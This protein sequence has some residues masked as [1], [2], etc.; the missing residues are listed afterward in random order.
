MAGP[1]DAFAPALFASTQEILHLQRQTA[2]Q[3]KRSEDLARAREAEQKANAV[4]FEPVV[5]YFAFNPAHMNKVL[6]TLREACLNSQAGLKPGDGAAL[7]SAVHERFE[8][9]VNALRQW[10]GE[11]ARRMRLLEAIVAAGCDMK[12]VDLLSAPS[13]LQSLTVQWDT[14]AQYFSRNSARLNNITSDLFYTVSEEDRPG[15]VAAD[16]E[17]RYDRKLKLLREW[18]FELPA[19]RLPVIQAWVARH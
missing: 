4:N 7:V 2:E 10:S 14:I 19:R 6:Y 13:A 15:I 8:E 5:S 9:Q 16:H 18:A 11:D 12:K 17:A 1:A 3:A